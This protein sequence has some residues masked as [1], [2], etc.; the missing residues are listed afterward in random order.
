[1]GK[2]CGWRGGS[3]HALQYDIAKHIID[4]RESVKER[5]KREQL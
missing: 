5:W 3:V 2:V 1:M 4:E